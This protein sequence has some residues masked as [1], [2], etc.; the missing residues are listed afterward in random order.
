MFQLAYGTSQSP[1][2]FPETLGLGELTE[3][4]GYEMSQGGKAL[5]VLLRLMLKNKL[6]EYSPVKHAQ[7]LAEKACLTHGLGYSLW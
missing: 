4:H 3:Y 2:D 1:A 6:G 5:G 7:N